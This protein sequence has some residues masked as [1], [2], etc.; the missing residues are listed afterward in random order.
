MPSSASTTTETYTLSLHDA[1][2]IYKAY[3][4]AMQAGEGATS[5][6]AHDEA[7][8]F[9]T[10]AQRHAA[11]AKERLEAYLGAAKVA[12]VSGR[13]AEAAELRSEEHTS[14]LQSHVNLVCRLLLRRPPRPTLFP[15]TTLFR[16]TRPIVM[17]CRPARARRASTRTTRPRRSSRWRSVTPRRRRSGSR[18]ISA[19][20][21]SRKYPGDTPKPRS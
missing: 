10:M 9:F 16:S 3:R 11:T 17:R 21:R 14:E 7:A 12:E 19:R 8:A 4:Y 6:Y 20:P 18:P 15:Y 5:V 1:L 13:Y 2:P